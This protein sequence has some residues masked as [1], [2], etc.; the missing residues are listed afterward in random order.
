M[1]CVRYYQ[2]NIPTFHE[3]LPTATC[4]PL[5][6]AFFEKF[7]SVKVHNELLKTNDP[8]FRY[9]F[10]LR[11]LTTINLIDRFNLLIFKLFTQLYLA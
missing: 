9:P 2:M 10:S 8:V 1:M 7:V 4:V 3:N 11:H 5:P 6:V